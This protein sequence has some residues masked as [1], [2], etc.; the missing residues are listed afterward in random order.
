MGSPFFQLGV[1]VP[2]APDHPG[3]S[4]AQR[5]PAVSTA[6][7]EQGAAEGGGFPEEAGAAGTQ[8]GRLTGKLAAGQSTCSRGQPAS[9]FLLSLL[10]PPASDAR[11]IHPVK[12]SSVVLPPHSR[13]LEPPHPPP[14]MLLAAECLFPV[15]S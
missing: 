7:G 11:I 4:F 15:L 2:S 1:S 9:L 3:L 14:F 5:V 10:R 8:S 12:A 13:L 6:L